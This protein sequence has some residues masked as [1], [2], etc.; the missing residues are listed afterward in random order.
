MLE[1]E[2]KDSENEDGAFREGR[3]ERKK[4]RETERE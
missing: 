2:R 3:V 1:N 4:E